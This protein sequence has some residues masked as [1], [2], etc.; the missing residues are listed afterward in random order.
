MVSELHHDINKPF[1]LYF[2][3]DQLTQ[4]IAVNAVKEFADIKL[5]SVAILVATL[6][7]GLG[8]IGRL[9]CAVADAAGERLVDERGVK[10]RIDD[11]INSMLHNKV[12]KGWRKYFPWLW[13]AH[14]KAIIRFCLVSTV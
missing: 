4:N 2:F 5:K 3:L 12:S 7:S 9:V 13:L 8:V 14:H 10:N 1:I 11:L 6:Q